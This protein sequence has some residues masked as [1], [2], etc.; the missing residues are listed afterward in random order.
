MPRDTLPGPPRPPSRPAPAVVAFDR[1]RALARQG[2]D[3]HALEVALSA[4]LAKGRVA[5]EPHRRAEAGPPATADESVRQ[6]LQAIQ[7]AAEELDGIALAVAEGAD[8]G[9]GAA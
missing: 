5:L 1:V 9:Q 2:H 7:A 3:G 6:F 8:D 4:A